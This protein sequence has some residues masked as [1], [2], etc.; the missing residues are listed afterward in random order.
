[1]ATP[2]K[3]SEE[4]AKE[5]CAICLEEMIPGSGKA[6]IIAGCGHMFHLECERKNVGHGRGDCPLCRNLPSA[7]QI[8]SGK[9]PAVA[10]FRRRQPPQPVERMPED[11][12][13]S[14]FAQ[15]QAVAADDARELKIEAKPESATVPVEKEVD[16]TV[17]LHIAA[18]PGVPRRAGQGVDLV[19]LVDQSESMNGERKMETVKSTLK[20]VIDK[21]IPSDRLAVIPFDDMPRVDRGLRSVTPEAQTELKRWVD[22]LIPRGGTQIQDAVSAAYQMMRERR[23]KNNFAAVL[24]L[25]DGVTT[26]PAM[27]GRQLRPADDDPALYTFGFGTDH[28]A[29]ALARM[30]T[31]RR[32]M[33][34]YVESA[35]NVGEAVGNCLG[36]LLSTFAQGIH[37]N[38][39]TTTPEIALMGFTGTA[40]HNESDA[41]EGHVDIPDITCGERKDI[42]VELRLPV[43]P[44]ADPGYKV[45]LVRADYCDETGAPRHAHAECCVVR[46]AE[47]VPPDLYVRAQRNRIAVAEALAEAARLADA[48]DVDGAL[49]VMEAAAAKIRAAPSAETADQKLFAELA[50]AAGAVRTRQVYFDGGGR[51][52]V[53]QRMMTHAYQRASAANDDLYSTASQCSMSVAGATA[54]SRK[55]ARKEE[56]EDDD[57]VV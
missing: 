27:R 40:Y 34:R 23:H 24:L 31:E 13:I 25:T 12:P 49:R 46:G 26:V 18:P 15:P 33:F 9:A 53:R 42:L 22:D 36:G 39:I 32:G 52:A 16:L 51:S 28:D 19:I 54:T 5:K 17:L 47:V 3:K 7:R 37:I 55:R 21:L 1:M 2:E 57:D 41:R 10:Q 11:E 48:G 29:D 45:L 30:A 43:S 50:D 56:E 8:V 14:V 4:E 44:S 35:D 38:V 20:F 6:I